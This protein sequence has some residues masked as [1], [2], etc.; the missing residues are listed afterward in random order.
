M[1][2]SYVGILPIRHACNSQYTIN[3]TTGI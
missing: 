1:A 3:R 2:W